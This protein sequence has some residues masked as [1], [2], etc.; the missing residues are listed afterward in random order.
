MN[1]RD[2]GVDHLDVAV[3]SRGDGVHEAILMAGIAPA[4]VA[5][6]AGAIVLRQ[7]APRRARAQHPQDAVLSMPIVGPWHALR[8]VG[9][10]RSDGR[11]IEIRRDIASAHDKAPTVWKLE[12]KRERL[13]IPIYGDID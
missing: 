2:R 7:I 6:R 3:A 8:L 9:R 4:V 12:S 11:P 13:V 10:K 5:G 1:T